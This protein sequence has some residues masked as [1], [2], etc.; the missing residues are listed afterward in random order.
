MVA[1]IAALTGFTRP[2]TA[3]AVPASFRTADGA[4]ACAALGGG[5][6][7]CRTRG[8]PRTVV[9]HGSGSGSTRIHVSSAR[10]TN[11]LLPAQSWW[12]AGVSCRADGARVTC[13]GGGG[14]IVVGG[15]RVAAT[16]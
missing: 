8:V 13:T 12:H 7:A 4:T 14:T 11:V 9:L 3:G 10:D 15:G 1:A 16:P 2:N 5:A 6:V